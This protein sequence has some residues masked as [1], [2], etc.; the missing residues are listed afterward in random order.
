MTTRKQSVVLDF[1]KDQIV[2]ALA[3]AG[4]ALPSPTPDQ[5]AIEGDRLELRWRTEDPEP[6]P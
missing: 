3:A 1:T 4:W 2:A 5:V 6:D